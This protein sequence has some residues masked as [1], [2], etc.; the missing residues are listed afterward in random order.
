MKVVANVSVQRQKSNQIIS[1]SAAIFG[2]RVGLPLSSVFELRE[3]LITDRHFA[4]LRY[5]TE[6]HQLHGA[7]C[8]MFSFCNRNKAAFAQKSSRVSDVLS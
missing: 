8:C 3:S 5:S 2:S 6:S 4:P 7:M 1:R